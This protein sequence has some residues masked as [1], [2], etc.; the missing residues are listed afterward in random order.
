MNQPLHNP[1]QVSSG[2]LIATLSVLAGISG[3]LIVSAWQF[4]LPTIQKSK[5]AY[6]QKAALEVIPRATSLKIE[7]HQGLRWFAGYHKDSLMG[8]AIEAQGMG[9]ADLIKLIYGYDSQ[10]QKVIGFRVLESKETPGL[11][12]KIEKDPH[13]LQNF[14]ELDYSRELKVVKQNKKT[15]A[16]EIDGITGATISSVAI[17]RILNSSRTSPILQAIHNKAV[18]HG[19]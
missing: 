3:L 13:F 2:R 14:K 1:N 15:Q 10:N 16:Y 8:Y 17:G 11:G 6:L 12:D 9:F 4:T 5:S 7:S 18:D 19:Q